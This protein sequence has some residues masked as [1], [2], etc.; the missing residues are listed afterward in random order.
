MGGEQKSTGYVFTITDVLF[1]FRGLR[2]RIVGTSIRSVSGYLKIHGTY[3]ICL[4]HA[5]SFFPGFGSI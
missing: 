3:V 2:R 5:M 1:T 4:L